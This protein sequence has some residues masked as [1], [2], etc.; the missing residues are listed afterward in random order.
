MAAIAS[1][2]D[3]SIVNASGDEVSLSTYSG[4]K[5]I[6]VVNVASEWGL[7]KQNYKVWHE[8]HPQQNKEYSPPPPPKKKQELAELY[9]KYSDKGLEILA[10]P[11]NQFGAQEPGTA[12]EVEAFA[13]SKGANFPV[14]EKLDVNG[15]NTHPL[16]TFLKS[17]V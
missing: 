13:R 11:C 4:K 16:Y 1:I 7:T 2:F 15:P 10:M 12:Q 9:E 14:M 17:S 3:I 6:L 8:I 5:A